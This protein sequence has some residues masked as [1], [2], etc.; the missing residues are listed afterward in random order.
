M[1]HNTVLNWTLVVQCNSYIG[2][3][4]LNEALKKPAFTLWKS[5]G[6]LW[7]KLEDSK[8]W[9]YSIFRLRHVRDIG[10]V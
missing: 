4:A 1:K 8:V 3:L 7:E 6:F 5:H 9:L 10:N 2:T